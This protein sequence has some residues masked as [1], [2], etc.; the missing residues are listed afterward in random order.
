MKSGTLMRQVINKLNEIDFNKASDRHE[1]GDIYEKLLGD[2]QSAGNAGEYYTPRAVTQFIV[3]QV[4]PQLDDK[5]LDPACGTGGFL[6]CAIGGIRTGV[7]SRPCGLIAVVRELSECRTYPDK[8]LGEVDAVALETN[9]CHETLALDA[10]G[11]AAYDATSHLL[12]MR[13]GAFTPEFAGHAISPRAAPRRVGRLRER[14]RARGAPQRPAA[15][16]SEADGPR[17]SPVVRAPT[18]AVAAS[19]N[20]TAKQRTPG[21]RARRSGSEAAA[22]PAPRVHASSTTHAR[23][24][25]ARLV[26]APRSRSMPPC[27]Y[28]PMPGRSLL[29]EGGVRD[30]RQRCA[31]PVIGTKRTSPSVS[32]VVPPGPRAITLSC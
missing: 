10:W 30:R 1:F 22:S 12:Y 14:S 3:D 21:G 15:E 7:S 19:A 11:R 5:I 27:P 4:D 9:R 13:P 32:V 25:A 2:L 20:P 17:G 24:R 16:R 26:R 31:S 28:A 29:G 23:A 8:G 18:S 6:T